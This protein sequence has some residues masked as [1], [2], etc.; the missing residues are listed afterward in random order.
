M[1]FTGDI[2][3]KI[4][5]LYDEKQ[6]NVR[7]LLSA[8]REK[9][10]SEIPEI[11]DIDDAISREGINL[12]MSKIKGQEYVP[13]EDMNDLAAKKEKLLESHGYSKDYL[14]NVY[15]CKVCKDTGYVKGKM[16]E[17][18][19]KEM[20][21]YMFDFSNI[22]PSL[23]NI[24]L[25]DFVLDYY[26]ETADEQGNIPK[27]KMKFILLK[28]KEF[29][30]DFDKKDVKSLFFFGSTGLGKTFLSAAIAKKIAEK[31]FSVLYY[32]AKQ[33]LSM[34]TDFD[35]GR[36]PEKKQ[37]CESIFSAD[38]LIIDDLG[39][40][41]QTAYSTAALFDIIN[42]RSLNGKKMIINT[43]LAAKDLHTLYS[44]R[45]FS[46]LNEFERLKFIGNDIRVIK[47]M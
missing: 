22:A 44:D 28:S 36:I 25:E 40:E 9:I 21:K 33:L 26:P 30:N 20:Q 24:S 1:I 42:T 10:Y 14:E 38:L 6:A 8:R 29:I 45:I 16:C 7:F 4:K 5:D 27:E 11:K 2:E 47:N 18:A 37:I 23:A 12:A 19:K 39:S 43:N 17:C 13:V 34:M 3:N 31:G 41:Q 15:N 46:R 32:S 35:F